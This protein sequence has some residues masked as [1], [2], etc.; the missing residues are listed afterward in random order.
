VAAAVETAAAAVAVETA[1][2]TAIAAAAVE[3]V[4]A[5]VQGAGNEKGGQLKQA[6]SG[7]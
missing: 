5:E 7:R 3:T 6:H 4:T 1:A 2:A